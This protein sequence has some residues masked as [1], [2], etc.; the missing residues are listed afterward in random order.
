MPEQKD[1]DKEGSFLKEKERYERGVQRCFGTVEFGAGR[2]LNKSIVLVS[3]GGKDGK[4]LCV[5]KMLLL[6]R[7]G[8][9]GE[10]DG[11]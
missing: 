7:I 10:I 11:E 5:G 4:W 3:A 2:V 8:S 9:K 6:F 1:Q